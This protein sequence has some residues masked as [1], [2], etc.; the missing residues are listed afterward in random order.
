MAQVGKKLREG[1]SCQFPQ[2]AIVA[3]EIEGEQ[4]L[5]AANRELIVQFE[6]KIQSTLASIWGEEERPA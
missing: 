2:R 5:I 1:R 3:E 4:A 6:R